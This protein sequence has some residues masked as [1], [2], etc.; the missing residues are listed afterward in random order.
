MTPG[1]ARVITQL[2]KTHGLT[3]HAIYNEIGY[4]SLQRFLGNVIRAGCGM[5]RGYSITNV[6][7]F[8]WP[9]EV[10]ERLLISLATTIL[11]N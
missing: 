6:L 1:E 8:S 9:G 11:R 7:Y 3:R 2:Y 5:R 10:G 4:L